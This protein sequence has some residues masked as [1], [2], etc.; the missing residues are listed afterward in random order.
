MKEITVD[1]VVENIDE[2]TDFVG[3]I[4]DELDCPMKIRMKINIAID[5]LLANI[6]YYAYQEEH[7]RVTVRVEVLEN[8]KAVSITFIDSGVPFNPLKKN[9]PDITLSAEDRKIGGLGIFMVKKNMDD[10]R[11]KYCDGMNQLQVIKYI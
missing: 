10:V 5:E 11:Y 9:D 6:A 2:V 3:F 1:A 4:L 7:G 8:P